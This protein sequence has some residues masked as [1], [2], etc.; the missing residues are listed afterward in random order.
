M[1]PSALTL[2]DSKPYTA[3][4]RRPAK[5]AA[6]Q[7]ESPMRPFA[8]AIR[9]PRPASVTPGLAKYIEQ[10]VR[11]MILQAE[12]HV[13]VDSDDKEQRDLARTAF[14]R[15]RQQSLEAMRG[16]IWRLRRGTPSG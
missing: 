9:A 15:A 11:R 1:M 14:I 5:Q 8:M 13:T 2:G 12:E 7:T 16:A 3:R 6:R 4:G 10:E